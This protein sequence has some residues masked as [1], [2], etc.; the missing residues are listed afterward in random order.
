[1]G[2]YTFSSRDFGLRL[3]PGF[4]GLSMLVIGTHQLVHLDGQK[5]N[6]KPFPEIHK[7]ILKSRITLRFLEAVPKAVSSLRH[8]VRAGDESPVIFLSLFP[9]PLKVVSVMRMF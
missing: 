5:R 1:M 2:K 4:T 9:P 8:S 7:N 6:R 3:L